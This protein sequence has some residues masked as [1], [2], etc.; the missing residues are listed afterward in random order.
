MMPLISGYCFAS[1][2]GFRQ[3]RGPNCRTPLAED[4]QDSRMPQSFEDPAQARSYRWCHCL[5]HSPADPEKQPLLFRVKNS[6][7]LANA[8]A[9]LRKSLIYVAAFAR[10]WSRIP[11]RGLF[12]RNPLLRMWP[13]GTKF[14]LRSLQSRYES[15]NSRL[16]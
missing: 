9:V 13:L 6:H 1:L 2:K 5:D 14:E 12:H 8:A 4:L 3:D 7:V 16:Y 15:G 11:K 10:T